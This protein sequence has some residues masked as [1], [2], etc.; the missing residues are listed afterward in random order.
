M[1]VF[2]YSFSLH[3]A[4]ALALPWLLFRAW[5]TGKLEDSTFWERF[6][7]IKRPWVS[8]VRG[9][10]PIWIHAVSV[11]E[12][13]MVSALAP[14]LKEKFPETPLVVSTNTVT[15]Q[16]IARKIEEVDGTFYVPIDFGWSV[17]RVLDTLQP[18]VLVI[19]ETEIWPNLI[20][21][22]TKRDIPVVFL[23]GRISEKSFRG[24]QKIRFFL[25]GLLKKAS[26][27]GM[28]SEENAERIIAL[29][30]PRDRV[31]VLGN[32]KFES[33]ARLS[34][35][36]IPL[37]RT[38]F[39]LSEEDLVLV[40]GSTFPGEEELL[41]EAYDELLPE[42]P[43][44]R[45]VL[46]P[47]HPERFEEAK[48]AILHSAHKVSLRS[49]G[50]IEHA[51]QDEA[52]PIILLDVMG[53]LRFVYALSDLVFIGK[54]MGLSEKGVGGQNPL[55]PAAFA[56]PILHGPHMQNFREIMTQLNEAK[57]TTEV[58][59]ETLVDKFRE[60]LQDSSLRE[61]KGKAGYSILEGA[62]GV[63][64]RCVGVV[65]EAIQSV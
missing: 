32:L 63:S 7:S 12:A 5:K 18:R 38:D 14:A 13:Q 56:K 60:L 46:A 42:F 3:L 36:E 6:G 54:S 28:Q 10:S 53:E 51:A 21:Q 17:R 2:F 15:G 26:A 48:Q 29:G 52:P 23:N 49:G 43:N 31:R 30:A 37:S 57:A 40:G 27:W 65:G 22:T 33:A 20:T 62:E 44:L 55:E 59:E 4:F 41:L 19:M 61:A 47:R 64:E 24:Y 50:T 34:K 16:N 39:G 1:W 11:G 8:E 35:A 25:S 45:L 9:K 58:T